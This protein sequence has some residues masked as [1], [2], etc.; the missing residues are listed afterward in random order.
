M[1]KL[2]A[3]SA[4]SMFLVVGS[5]LADDQPTTDK[6]ISLDA[7]S[8]GSLVVDGGSSF[9]VIGTKTDDPS[10]EKIFIRQ[11]G[12]PDHPWGPV[13]HNLKV[14]RGMM[15]SDDF[16][17]TLKY[18]MSKHLK[19]TVKAGKVVNPGPD[20]DAGKKN[21][22]RKAAAK[23]D[24]TLPPYLSVRFTSI[25]DLQ[26]VKT[27]G[28][29]MSITEA[30]ALKKLEDGYQNALQSLQNQNG[31]LLGHIQLRQADLS[32][33]NT[34]VAFGEVRDDL[35]KDLNDSADEN[36]KEQQRLAQ[37]SASIAEIQTHFSG[38]VTNAATSK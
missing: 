8:M 4:V 21:A 26:V 24:K 17:S 36:T 14:D 37:I 5:V 6:P 29:T 16:D 15:S 32:P 10:A 19:L 7:P 23:A 1:K 20:T 18:V 31:T 3:L 25:D 9:D 30:L 35:V 28:T 27:D 2:I 38:S 13:G 11:V 33:T 34:I 12:A 22:E